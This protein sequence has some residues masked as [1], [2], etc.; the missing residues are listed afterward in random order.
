MFIN[1]ELSI[2]LDFS[3]RCLKRG[4]AILSN[5]EING[6]TYHTYGG[7]IHAKITTSY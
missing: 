7:V 5:H 2:P 1:Q 6:G 4:T 3:M